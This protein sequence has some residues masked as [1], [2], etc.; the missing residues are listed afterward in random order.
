M[1]LLKKLLQKHKIIYVFDKSDKQIFAKF[2][3]NPPT[4]FS[5]FQFPRL[6]FKVSENDNRNEFS[7]IIYY[8]MKNKKLFPVSSSTTHQLGFLKYPR[9]EAEF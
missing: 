9:T 3:Y 8:K 7:S 6:L 1:L 2:F 5:R 4:F